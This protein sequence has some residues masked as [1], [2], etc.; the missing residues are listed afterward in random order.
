MRPSQEDSMDCRTDSR[1]SGQAPLK[2]LY[3]ALSAS[4][5]WMENAKSFINSELGANGAI[6]SRR[7]STAKQLER[8]N[9]KVRAENKMIMIARAV[10]CTG[11]ECKMICGILIF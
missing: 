1:R 4:S 11:Y 7:K 8:V 2:W 3:V 10:K 5:L 9:V 6:N